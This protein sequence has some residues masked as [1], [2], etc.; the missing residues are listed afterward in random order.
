MK[1]KLA[2][3]AA[4]LILMTTVIACPPS[5]TEFLYVKEVKSSSDAMN[6]ID[7][8]MNVHNESRYGS[9]MGLL[10][11]MTINNTKNDSLFRVVLTEGAN[12]TI[13][14]E[15]EI[16][17]IK[18]SGY[19]YGRNETYDYYEFPEQE[20]YEKIRSMS[21]NMSDFDGGTLFIKLDNETLREYVI[22]YEPVHI[23]D[24]SYMYASEQDYVILAGAL[25]A[26]AAVAIVIAVL[27]LKARKK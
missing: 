24:C 2:P 15:D 17:K 4:L 19:H 6:F 18:R 25:I 7:T 23:Y 14:F 16:S 9:K 5:T 26:V 21:Q 11:W 13:L 3:L 1:N 27:A 8:D 22:G 10:P 12:E 20:F